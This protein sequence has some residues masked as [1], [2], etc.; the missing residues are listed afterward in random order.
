MP[1]PI[2]YL[3]SLERIS[4]FQPDVARYVR[5]GQNREGNTCKKRNFGDRVD[6]LKRPAGDISFFCSISHT[7]RQGKKIH[8]IQKRLKGRK[9]KKKT[10]IIN[11]I[12]I[13]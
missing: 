9:E 5:R 12:A 2:H 10:P 3:S 6:I 8:C 7:V 1:S 13:Q 4:F 11:I